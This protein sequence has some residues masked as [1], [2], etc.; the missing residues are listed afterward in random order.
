M[1][2][3]DGILELMPE[4]TMLQTL[5]CALSRIRKGTELDLDEMT[6][7]LDVLA[8]KHLPDDIAFMVIDRNGR[9]G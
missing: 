9:H 8:D 6:A 2:V 5:Q 4:D 3:S 7:G 1:L